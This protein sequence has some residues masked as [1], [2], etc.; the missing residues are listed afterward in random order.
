M[1]TL[2]VTGTYNN[3]FKITEGSIDVVSLFKSEAFSTRLFGSLITGKINQV[4]L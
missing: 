1:L 3:L 4:Q 2:L